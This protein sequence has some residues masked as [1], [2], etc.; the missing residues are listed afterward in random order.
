[1]K[2]ITLNYSESNML[3]KRT[4]E[5]ILSLGVFEQELKTD[6]LNYDKIGRLKLDQDCLI[7]QGKM[8][9]PEMTVGFTPEERKMFDNGIPMETVFERIIEKCAV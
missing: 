5:Y 6:K 4:V 9:K 3:A 1:M 7:A 2:S 8:E